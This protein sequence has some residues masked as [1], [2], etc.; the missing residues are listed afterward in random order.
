MKPISPGSDSS[1]DFS[2]YYEYSQNS[3]TDSVGGTV[4]TFFL[5]IFF[6]DIEIFFKSIH[7]GGECL[8]AGVGDST[9]GARLFALKAL[10]DGDVLSCSE[11]VELNAQIA[12]GRL[13]VLLEVDE[14]G[15]YYVH[16]HLHHSESQLREQKGIEIFHI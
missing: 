4:L 5:K 6:L 14:I 9:S 11:F 15:F 13:G 8:A 16:Q 12:R 2:N 7:I 1:D 3:S 10:L